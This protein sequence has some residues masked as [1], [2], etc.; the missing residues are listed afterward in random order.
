[1]V[2]LQGHYR[3]CEALFLFGY[4]KKAIEANKSAQKLCKDDH[5]GMKDLEQ[6][7]FKFFAETAQLKGV[8]AANHIS[9]LCLSETV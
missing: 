3:Y 8:F 9:F 7:Q 2:C 6:Q 4:A 1:M 5:E